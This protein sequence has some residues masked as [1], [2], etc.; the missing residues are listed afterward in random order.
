VRCRSQWW[1]GGGGDGGAGERSAGWLRGA[2]LFKHTG[3]KTTSATTREPMAT[4]AAAA[5]TPR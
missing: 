3:E 4:T 5:A 1:S 2:S